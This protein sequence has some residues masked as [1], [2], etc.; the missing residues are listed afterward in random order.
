MRLW[1]D[2]K[3]R[4]LL[5]LI[6]IL[7]LL[8]CSIEVGFEIISCL[9]ETWI[10][11]FLTNQSV[12]NISENLIVGVLSAYFF[13]VFIDFLPRLKRERKAK[14]V[15]DSLLS[16]ILDA[17]KRCRLFGHETAISHVDK[18]G[19]DIGWLRGQ[20]ADLKSQQTKFLPLKFA[21]QTAHTRLEDFRH[22]LPLA[23]TLSPERAMQWLVIIDKVRL[24]AESYG[25][26]PDVPAENMHLIDTN[27]EENPLKIYKADLNFRFLE[28]VEQ[29]I[30]WQ[31]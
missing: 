27:H 4:N 3:E 19:L 10:G 7:F 20:I 30:E 26:Q 14:F 23:V 1:T 2:K 25:E 18:T 5:F 29:T 17:F 15:L 22:V 8:L 9:S 28:F 6:I 13:Y 21:M 12:R 16:S 24:L 31:Q 11:G